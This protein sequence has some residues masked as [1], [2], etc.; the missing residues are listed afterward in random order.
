MKP[1]LSLPFKLKKV[2]FNNDELHHCVLIPL[3]P[4]SSRYPPLAPPPT[5]V[6]PLPFPYPTPPPSRAHRSHSPSP[7]RPPLLPLPFPSSLP[8]LPLL[9]CTPSLS[10]PSHSFHSLSLFINLTLAIYLTLTITLAILLTSTLAYGIPNYRL[11]E[12]YNGP[13]PLAL[14]SSPCLHAG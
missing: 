12:C 2:K 6:P 5:L 14:S 3:S 8:R 10:L 13:S 11:Y 4:T 7:T 1:Y 9:P